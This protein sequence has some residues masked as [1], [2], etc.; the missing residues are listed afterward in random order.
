MEWE[1]LALG[2]ALALGVVL[3]LSAK[4]RISPRAALP[5]ALFVGAAAGVLW[6]WDWLRAGADLIPLAAAELVTVVLATGAAVAFMFYRDPERT[7]PPRKG[8][9]LSPADGE[10]VYVKRIEDGRAPVSEKG[11]RSFALEEL[12]DI[13]S[14]HSGFLIGVGMN[15]LNVHVNRA[16][17]GGRVVAARRIE[18][19][20][21]SL[22]TEGMVLRN[23]RFTTVVRDGDLEVAVV[24]IASRLVR[25]IVSYLQ[26]GQQVEVGQRIGM[27]KFGSQVDTILPD[28]PGLAIKVRPGD[29]VKAGL[30]VIA[31]I[32]DG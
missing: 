9:V 5:W 7:S 18:G 31:E 25:R 27:I 29:V 3:P 19:G 17:V 21:G 10:V 16:P 1:V 30:T 24:Q 28:T 15:L 22:G 2:I 32:E 8:A 14:A 4:W 20:F 13:G 6:S 12:S 11:G 23:E 26:E